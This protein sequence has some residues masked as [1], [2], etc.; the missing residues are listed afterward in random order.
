[1]ALFSRKITTRGYEPD[2]FATVPIQRY[3]NYLEW[4]RWEFIQDPETGLLEGLQSGHFPVVRSQRF[5]LIQRVGMGRDLLLWA[6]VTKVGRSTVTLE[7][8]VVAEDDGSLVAHAIVEGLWLGPSRRLVR[9]PDAFRE[10]AEQHAAAES[11]KFSV[12]PVNR[13]AGTGPLIH[14]N[15][16]PCIFERK[17]LDLHLYDAP[18]STFTSERTIRPSDIDIFSHVNAATYV[19]MFEDALYE[20]FKTHAFDRSWPNRPGPVNRLFI[21]YDRESL[22]DESLVAHCWEA[23]SEGFAFELRRRDD[24]AVLCRATLFP[25]G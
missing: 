22:L 8:H 17:G 4:L 23:D 5:E 19:D 18:E 6:R 2:R 14:T 21:H 13:P 9:I 11:P 12:L 20:A 25:E 7:H 1:M 16:K 15:P 24:D 10:L 3:L